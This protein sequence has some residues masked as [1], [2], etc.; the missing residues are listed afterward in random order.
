MALDLAQTLAQLIAD[1]PRPRVLLGRLALAKALDAACEG[2]RCEGLVLLEQ[3]L[4]PRRLAKRCEGERRRCV[5]ADR[6]ALPL[7]PGSVGTVIAANVLERGDPAEHIERLCRVLCDGG[8]LIL[9]ESLRSATG[10]ALRSF[11]RGL[12]HLLPEDLTTLLLGTDVC[13]IVQYWPASSVVTVG[14]LRRL[15]EG[16]VGREGREGREGRRDER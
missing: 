16:R 8:R 12:N 15:E 7:A 3:Q 9:V 4:A 6:G 11:G 1:Q 10:H 14:R 5:R 13:E 2:G